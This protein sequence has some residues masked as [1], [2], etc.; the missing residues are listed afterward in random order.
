MADGR[1]DLTR[2]TL[3]VI[4]IAGLIGSSLLILSPFLA[5]IIWGATLV[6]ATW[7]LLT[8]VQR[9]LWNKRS[10]A[11]TV[12]TLAILLIFVLPFWA[13]VGT[14]VQNGGQLIDWVGSISSMG[15]P[16]PPAW[17]GE[18]PLLGAPAVNFWQK[19]VD[20]GVHS[21]LQT[22]RPYAGMATQWF[23]GAVGSLGLILV[24]FLLTVL[25]AAMM[26]ARGE[27]GAAAMIRFG[28]R[29]AGARGERSVQLAGHAI[30]GVAL[31][32]VVTALIQTAVASA[33]L[34]I[35]GVPFAPILSAVIFLLCLAQIG[36][37]LVLIP[38]VIWMYG[39][40]DPLWAS[41]LLVFSLVAMTIDNILRPILIRTGVDLPLILILVGVVGGL[42]AFGI[43]GIFIGP[44]VLAVS[45]TLLQEWIAEGADA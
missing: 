21:L 14:I 23:I 26:Y 20:A 18:S 15:L 1:F 33:G 10:L 5:P 45:Y 24:Q 38:A 11:V 32:V 27:A 41:V 42:I 16:P 31:G 22:A 29:L 34:F 36:P 2:L 13:A 30:R 3:A 9:L 12:M 19:T 8:R 4:F 17:L 6:I 25:F 7:P 35:A 37:A 28:R 40:G 44:T 39:S 43:I